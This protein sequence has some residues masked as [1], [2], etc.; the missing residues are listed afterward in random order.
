MKLTMHKDAIR[1]ATFGDRHEKAS[2]AL[3]G[4]YYMG[5]RR[6]VEIAKEYK[7]VAAA[8]TGDSRVDC[9]SSPEANECEMTSLILPLAQAGISYW[10]IDG[11]HDRR[12][13]SHKEITANSWLA[14]QKDKDLWKGIEYWNDYIP[15]MMHFGTEHQIQVLPL[16][17]PPRHAFAAGKE[18]KT[19]KELDA[20]ASEH[21]QAALA[22]GAR[23]LDPKDPI[24]ILYHGTV[25]SP[26]LQTA[27]EARMPAGHDVNIPVNA[28]PRIPNCA[29]ACGHIHMHQILS[30]TNPLIY[31]TGPLIPQ[32]FD[33][34]GMET[35]V[36]ILEFY[37]GEVRY[38]FVPVDTIVYKTVRID[39]GAGVTDDEIVKRVQA[40]VPAPE[41]TKVRIVLRTEAVYGIDK[42]ALREAL[43]TAG[44]IE[45]GITVEHP[46]APAV[47]E[48]EQK[49]HEEIGSNVTANVEAYLK[50]NPEAV[51]ALEAAGAGT[52]DALDATKEIEMEA[53]SE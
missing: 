16:P 29:V 1:I 24:L 32:E 50:E 33:H 52:Q 5:Q 23:A 47:L 7:C 4:P 39:V 27:G 37:Q 17:Y 42:G 21:I 41:R 22:K 12:G 18:M 51:A 11:N 25:D 35:G 31:Y 28:F 45:P 53:F 43:E 30:E 9:N 26:R 3:L 8:D 44:I 38:E 46:E 14:H 6:I 20:A 10:A 49:I 19:K 36:V 2:R 15:R 34:E 48:T 13:A 40:E